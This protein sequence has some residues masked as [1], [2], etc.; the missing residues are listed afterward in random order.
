[1]LALTL[2]GLSCEGGGSP[3]EFA[4]HPRLNAQSAS[5]C[6]AQ[7]VVWLERCVSV[8]SGLSNPLRGW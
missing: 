4:V 1:M 5:G 8:I 6:G 3:A 2:I 7:R